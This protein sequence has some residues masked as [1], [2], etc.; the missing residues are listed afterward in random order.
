MMDMAETIGSFAEAIEIMRYPSPVFVE[1][2]AL[3]GKPTTTTID[4][5]VQ[6][7][8]G[9]DVQRL[10]EN[11]RETE[12]I[13]VWCEYELR[14]ASVEGRTLSDRVVWEGRQYE[15]KN[16][17]RWKNLGNYVKAICTRVGQ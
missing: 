11:L 8:T 14:G 17:E 3:N 9:R 7:T 13:A 4:A 10:P 1:G 12:S 2:R 15:V 5:V 6:P 16:I